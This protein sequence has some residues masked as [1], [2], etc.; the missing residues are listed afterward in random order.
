ML[1]GGEK[2]QIILKQVLLP[3]IMKKKAVPKGAAF[4]V[5]SEAIIIFRP[6]PVFPFLL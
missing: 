3:D 4:F 6:E 2:I 5:D 1:I